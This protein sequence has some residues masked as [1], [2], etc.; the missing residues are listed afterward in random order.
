MATPVVSLPVPAVVGTKIAVIQCTAEVSYF[1]RYLL[2]NR[3]FNGTVTGLPLPIGAL[4]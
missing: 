3:G 4:T 1:Q 2:A